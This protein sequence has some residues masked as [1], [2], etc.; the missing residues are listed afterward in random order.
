MVRT[1]RSSVSISLMARPVTRPMSMKI[2]IMMKY[3]VAYPVACTK[4]MKH[5]SPD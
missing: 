3:P 5:V 1:G 2:L 4:A